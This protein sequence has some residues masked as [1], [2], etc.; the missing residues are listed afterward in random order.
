MIE[1][2]LR[3]PATFSVLVLTCLFSAIP[4]TADTILP[5]PAISI[6][7]DDIGYRH[8]D[9]LKAIALPGQIAFAIMPHSPY[10]KRMSRLANATGRIVLLHLPMQAMDSGKDRFLGPGALRLDMTHQQFI[11]TLEINLRA[12]PDAIGVNNHMG[13]LLSGQT[14]SMQWLMELL[15]EKKKFYLDSLTSGQSVARSAAREEQV[16]FLKR[17]VFLDNQRDEQH[18]QQQF[19]KLITLAKLNGNAVA[20]GHPHPE[21]ISVLSRNLGQLGSLGVR[22]INPADMAGV[23]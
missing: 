12:V 17:D 11:Q 13:S 23:N 2:L 22:L 18:I 7:I 10:G 6:I 20:I 15:S 3:K 8:G 5:L 9:D 16:P 19:D 4:A 14:E 21:T 1:G